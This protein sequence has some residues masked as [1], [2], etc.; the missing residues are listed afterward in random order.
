MATKIVIL[1]LAALAVLC[2]VD[3]AHAAVTHRHALHPAHRQYLSPYYHH[4][5]YRHYY[6]TPSPRTS[7]PPLRPPPSPP[8]PRHQLRPRQPRGAGGG[9]S[10]GGGGGAGVLDTGARIRSRM[11]L[12]RSPSR[13][14]SHRS[15]SCDCNC[16][17]D[18]RLRRTAGRRSG[19][20]GRG[21]SVCEVRTPI[22]PST[23]ATFFTVNTGDLNKIK[24]KDN[25]FLE[26]TIKKKNKI[27]REIRIMY[28]YFGIDCSQ[29]WNLRQR[30]T[31]VGDPEWV[32]GQRGS[33]VAGTENVGGAKGNV[34]SIKAEGS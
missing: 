20:G 9:G 10:R 29:M 30:M 34:D 32:N 1:A 4:Y 25:Q 22:L 33:V 2:L 5:P 17:A 28:E 19:Q 8:R 27:S 13:S 18:W 24:Y 7:P 31:E 12:L 3:D 26:I 16:S 15:S 21:W 6:A 11:L 14:C 23:A